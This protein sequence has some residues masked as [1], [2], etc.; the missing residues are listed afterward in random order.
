VPLVDCA[1]LQPPLAVQEV[2]F[3]LDQV[4]VEFPPEAMVVGLAVR[5]TVGAGPATFTAKLCETDGAAA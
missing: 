3:V 5:L 4:S 2:A 1:P